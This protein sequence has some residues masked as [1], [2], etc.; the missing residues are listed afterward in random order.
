MASKAACIMLD[1][2]SLGIL[3]EL[4]NK[5]SKSMFINAAIRHYY[6]NCEEARKVFFQNDVAVKPASSFTQSTAKQES[7]KS[8]EETHASE[9]KEV[10]PKIEQSEEQKTA[11]TETQKTVG[12]KLD[13]W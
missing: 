5:R 3:D 7:L 10:A 6:E 4:T 9:E 2:S 12:V 13:D 8:K 1:D 11:S